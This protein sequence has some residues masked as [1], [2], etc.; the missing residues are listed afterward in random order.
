VQERAFALRSRAVLAV[1][2]RAGGSL[3]DEIA[4][5]LEIDPAGLDRLLREMA[6]RGL[7]RI[8]ESGPVS[9]SG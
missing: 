5:A 6:K 8:G 4:S 7:I 2:W 9:E 1:L 3:S